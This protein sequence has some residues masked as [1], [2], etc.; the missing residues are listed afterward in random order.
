MSYD[1]DTSYDYFT[2]IEKE[3]GF[4]SVWSMYDE[5]PVGEMDSPSPYSDIQ[6]ILYQCYWDAEPIQLPVKENTWRELWRTSDALIRMSGDGHHIFIE[7][8]KSRG[9]GVYELYTGS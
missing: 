4:K 9:D 1:F 8:F 7:M 3:E 5:V 6:E 2:A